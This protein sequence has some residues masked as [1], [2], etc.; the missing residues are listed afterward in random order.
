[1]WIFLGCGCSKV[2]VSLH[3]FPQ[4]SQRVR[5]HL[6]LQELFSLL[7]LQD[8]SLAFFSPDFF[9][10]LPIRNNGCMLG[11]QRWATTNCLTAQLWEAA[12]V[13]ARK[14][15]E[16]VREGRYEGRKGRLEAEQMCW[17]K[18]KK[19]LLENNFKIHFSVWRKRF[20]YVYMIDNLR[21]LYNI[22]FIAINSKIN[23]IKMC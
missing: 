9:W 20:P 14:S 19:G 22:V 8:A 10:G 11:T 13:A 15:E 18:M 2:K 23:L 5:H 12:I 4:S 1:M 6:N 17:W 7:H 21:I 16:G 3:W